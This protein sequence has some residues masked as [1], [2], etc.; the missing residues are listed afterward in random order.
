VKKPLV[1][2]VGRPTKKTPRTLDRLEEALT[3]G[4]PRWAACAY[5]RI[6]RQTFNDWLQKQ[7]AFRAQV[8]GW[9]AQAMFDMVERARREPRG[10]QWLLAR[11]FRDDY[12]D[13]VSVDIEAG[14]LPITFV[15]YK[16][17][18]EGVATGTEA[19]PAGDRTPPGE[20]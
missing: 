14:P 8:E 15:N 18:I 10:N 7:P 4:M 20:A 2:K 19:G 9:E 13:R 16:D 1:R 11:R 3:K 17:G 12:G 6:S 5:A